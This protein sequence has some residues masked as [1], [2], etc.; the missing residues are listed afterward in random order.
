MIM[1][2]FKKDFLLLKNTI[3]SI[4][5]I[6]T[7]ILLLMGLDKEGLEITSL[8][9]IENIG[10][11]YVG[12][13]LMVLLTQHLALKDYQ[14]PKAEAMI[15]IMPY[16]RRQI[17]IARY[18]FSFCITFVIT[19]LFNAEVYLLY[20]I[21]LV[22]FEGIILFIFVC[23]LYLA[24][25]FP[26]QYRYGYEKTRFIFM[27]LIVMLSVG[28]NTIPIEIW[29]FNFSNNQMIILLLGISVVMLLLSISLSIKIY[30]NKD[31]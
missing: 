20:Q 2:L 3:L 5:V 10:F 18:L 14:F 9:R 7:I 30:E 4:V 25:Y 8:M 17:V 29:Q 23:S 11:I 28:V 26:I 22:R 27:G 1:N 19:L 12:L 6:L 15:C 16:S 21:K 13:F 24:I 31:F